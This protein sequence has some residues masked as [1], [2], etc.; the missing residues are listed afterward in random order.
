[1]KNNEADIE[2]EINRHLPPAYQSEDLVVHRSGASVIVASGRS[3]V[4][5]TAHGGFNTAIGQPYEAVGSISRISPIMKKIK[6]NYFA[7]EVPER[8]I[9]LEEDFNKTIL[10]RVQQST[11]KHESFI[12]RFKVRKDESKLVLR[13]EI[14]ISSNRLNRS[15]HGK[16]NFP[17]TANHSFQIESNTNPVHNCPAEKP[18]NLYSRAWQSIKHKERQKSF[19]QKLSFY[20]E[21]P[22]TA[23][24]RLLTHHLPWTIPKLPDP[25]STPE[26]SRFYPK[27]LR[28]TSR[29]NSLK[30][31]LRTTLS[32]PSL[33]ISYLTAPGILGKAGM[34]M[35]LRI[36]NDEK[37]HIKASSAEI[38]LFNSLV[39]RRLHKKDGPSFKKSLHEYALRKLHN[40]P[41][42]SA[43]AIISKFFE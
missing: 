28:K 14:A 24:R 33:T 1:M 29:T 4:T 43:S 2:K 35:L 26:N 22:R 3:R 42:P 10:K 36:I 6:A 20:Q 15:R 25:V 38:E 9:R 40:Q 21:S 37:H 30:S 5:K 18:S 16:R 17:Q 34:S 11:Q 8:I 7:E 32:R 12:D 19:E 31:I 39:A 13:R 27:T 41:T 23:K